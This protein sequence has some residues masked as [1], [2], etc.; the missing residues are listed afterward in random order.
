MHR[1]A[2]EGDYVPG[3]ED[4]HQLLHRRLAAKLNLTGIDA[5]ALIQRHRVLVNGT[6]QRVD[7]WLQAGDVVAVN[8][9]CL[10]QLAK[11]TFIVHKPVGFTLTEE[12][13]L[14][15][16]TY[17]LLL[18]DRMLLAR[19]VGRLDIG[20]SGLLVLTNSREVADSLEE[21]S[22]LSATF[23]IQLR[24]PLKWSQLAAL[25][26]VWPYGGI[27]APEL[28]Q[29]GMCESTGRVTL[30]VT[31]RTGRPLH[32]RRALVAV[33]ASGTIARICCIRLGPLS[34]DALA[35]EEPGAVRPVSV[36]EL[37][38]VIRDAA[39]API[40][41]AALHEELGPAGPSS[42]LAT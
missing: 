27:E 21:R 32:L 16:P 39:T 37:T 28:V 34:L 40:P 35:L 23:D 3:N 29:Q 24:S 30:R 12:D 17:R 13:P 25:R 9:H 41:S 19:P 2:A 14:E 42:W 1:S 7:R 18:P 8:G 31:S 38:A 22:G 15:R 33:G 11:L 4:A 36:A 6:L 20:A 10:D 5:L 26:G